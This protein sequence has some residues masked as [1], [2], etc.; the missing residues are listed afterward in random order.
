M[1]SLASKKLIADRARLFT[2]LAL[3][4]VALLPGSPLYGQSDLTPAGQG[5]RRSRG[6][7]NWYINKAGPCPIWISFGSWARS[8]PSCS[9]LRFSWKGTIQARAEM[10]QLA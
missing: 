10:S 7:T 5:T 9:F 6:S 8:A 1:N 4:C 2:K 3:H